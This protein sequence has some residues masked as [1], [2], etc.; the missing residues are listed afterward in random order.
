M[1]VSQ[2]EMNKNDQRGSDPLKIALGVGVNR[3]IAT[4][5]RGMKGSAEERRAAAAREFAM[6]A[7][8]V[9]IARA[10]DPEP[11]ASLALLPDAEL[12]ATFA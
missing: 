10:S 8:A 3:L 5:A 6:P 7:G 1:R 11:G 9:V 2:E 4:L 12:P